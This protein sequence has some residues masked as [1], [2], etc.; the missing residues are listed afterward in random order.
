MRLLPSLRYAH[1]QAYVR[2]VASQLAFRVD[3]IFAAPLREDQG[4]EIA[5]WYVFLTK[6][7]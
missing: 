5:A 1:S 3:E 4:A 6:L 7:A 2:R